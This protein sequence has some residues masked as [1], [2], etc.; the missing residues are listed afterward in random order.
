MRHAG[1]VL[2]FTVFVAACAS[3]GEP[4]LSVPPTA[5][6]SQASPS[7]ATPSPQPAGLLFRSGFEEG[8]QL[9]A[10]RL[11]FTQ[12]RQYL[13]GADAGF[14]WSAALPARLANLQYLVYD[15]D[16]VDKDALKGFVDTRIETVSGR[17][18][19][20]T[21]A[22]YQE[23]R[24]RGRA[25]TQ[26]DFILFDWDPSRTQ[27]YLRYWIKLQPDLDRVM[28]SPGIWRLLMEWK[29]TPS[30]PGITGD[31]QYRW[32]FYLSNVS[33]PQ[34]SGLAWKLEAS[35]TDP[36]VAGFTTDWAKWNYTVPVPRGEWFLIEVEWVNHPTDGKIRVAVNDRV[37][38]EHA[39]PT[40]RAHALG[41][42]YLFMVYTAVESTD[43][44]PAYQWVDDVELWETP[45]GR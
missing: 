1:L 2:I 17:G 34:H 3:S 21:R 20:M 39:G 45:P 42:L 36:N 7:P 15:S 38:A 6:S 5:T 30:I 44:G 23:V 13:R 25:A 14:D 26:N 40:Q 43:I 37:I 35:R 16:A 12:W 8:V 19:R 9:D 28:P 10:P 31:F 33:T 27:G 22:L 32:G 4:V 41:K 24:R 11:E 29:E 18:G